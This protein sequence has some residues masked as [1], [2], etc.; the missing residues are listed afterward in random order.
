MCVCDAIINRIGRH[1]TLYSLAHF[2]SLTHAVM[3]VVS[4]L[5]LQFPLQFP[6]Q[7]QLQSIMLLDSWHCPVSAVNS[8]NILEHGEASRSDTNT[9]LSS[10]IGKNWHECRNVLCARSIQ[11][12]AQTHTH[13]G[14]HLVSEHSPL[15]GYF[16]VVVL[17]FV[18]VLVVV[19][20]VLIV[21]IV[22]VVVR[23]ASQRV[24]FTQFRMKVKLVLGRSSVP[25]PRQDV[26]LCSSCLR[27]ARHLSLFWFKLH[28]T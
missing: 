8:A 21:L 7:L 28:S 12:H 22:L 16:S 6:L 23:G 4:G 5:Q 18:L 9:K 2:D 26:V 13:R 27:F 19:L 15:Q 17:V 25:P 11:T 10:A 1:S 3:C 24:V 14:A 20:D